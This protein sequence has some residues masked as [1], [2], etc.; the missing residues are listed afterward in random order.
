MKSLESWRFE[1][2][3]IVRPNRPFHSCL[4][5]RHWAKVRLRVTLFWSKP[6]CFSYVNDAALAL[7]NNNLHK[8]Y[9]E[10]SAKTRSPPASFS[11]KGRAT[12]HNCK[13]VY[14]ALCCLLFQLACCLS[15][16]S[17]VDPKSSSDDWSIPSCEVWPAIVCFSLGYRSAVRVKPYSCV[18]WQ[19]RRGDS[20]PESSLPVS[21]PGNSLWQWR[22]AFNV[23][24]M[25]FS[26]MIRRPCCCTKQ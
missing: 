10:V 11:F 4:L 14:S 22:F 15:E 18:R 5:S 21:Q 9:R 8:K 20:V 23:Q 6:P 7:M 12:K 24:Q 19:F 3:P 13:M 26:H 16:F 2:S 1:R 17:S 25:V